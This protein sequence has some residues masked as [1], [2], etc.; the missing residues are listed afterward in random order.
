MNIRPMLMR[1]DVP[2]SLEELRFAGQHF[3]ELQERD[4]RRYD[5][6]VEKVILDSAN[7]YRTYVNHRPFKRYLE[8]L[9]WYKRRLEKL[10]T[11]QDAKE[12]CLGPLL[13]HFEMLN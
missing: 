7:F 8:R 3:R 2:G 5:R 4:C 1:G 11:I 12:R 9:K 13:L 10:W 6:Y